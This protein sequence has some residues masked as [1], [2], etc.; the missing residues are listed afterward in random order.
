V[1]R[2][3]SVLKGAVIVKEISIIKHWN[4]VEDAFK[5]R[6]HPPSF[7]TWG[8]KRSKDF[9]STRKHTLCSGGTLLQFQHLGGRGGKISEFQ[10][11]VSSRRVRVTQ[12]S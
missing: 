10:A 1:L 9:S 7:P 12:D 11:R 5:G 2:L 8:S 3:R 4:I 6:F